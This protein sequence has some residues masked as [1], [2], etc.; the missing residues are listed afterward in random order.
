VPAHRSEREGHHH[1]ESRSAARS[2]SGRS[3]GGRRRRCDENQDEPAVSPCWVALSFGGVLAELTN[4][5]V[6]YV[7]R[8]LLLGH[9]RRGL[10]GDARRRLHTQVWDV[11]DQGNPGHRA[12]V[13]G[14]RATQPA[15]PVVDV[16]RT[17]RRRGQRVRLLRCAALLE[18]YGSEDAYA[19]AGL[20]AALVA[21]AQI[22]GGAL[23]GQSTKLFRRRTSLLFVGSAAIVA[24]LAVIGLMAHLWVVMALV[25]VW[26]LL[27]FMMLPVRQA[28]LNGLI[29]SAQR[30]RC[31]PPTTCSAQGAVSCSSP[32]WARSPTS[33][34]TASPTSSA[35]ASSCSRCRW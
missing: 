35:P 24:V 31:C 17:L 5:G 33:G 23:V 2:K 1:V 34:A 22:A 29:P 6:P 15:G 21:G 11:G 18:L 12:L 4:L 8:A 28:F 20:S 3:S 19:I 30:R 7:L 16:G 32:R 25:A 13:P 9:A 10:G 14:P 26:G 27:F